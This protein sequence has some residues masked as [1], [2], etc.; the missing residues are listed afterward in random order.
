MDHILE[1]GNLLRSGVLGR[2]ECVSRN[3]VASSL[4]DSN[5]ERGAS[6]GLLGWDRIRG[7]QSR[8]WD[9]SRSQV[10]RVTF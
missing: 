6:E 3:I 10:S 2:N 4:A 1:E 9:L 8:R 7:D 5:R